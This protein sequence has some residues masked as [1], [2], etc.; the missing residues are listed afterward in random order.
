VVAVRVPQGSIE[1]GGERWGSDVLVKDDPNHEEGHPDMVSS[2]DGRFYVAVEYTDQPRID[3]LISDDGGRHWHSW[4]YVTATPGSVVK[5][6]ALAVPEVTRDWLYLTA[7]VNGWIH[8][9]ALSINTTDTRDSYVEPDPDS[10]GMPRITTDDLDYSNYYIYLMYNGAR[11][12]R[13]TDKGVNWT[14][15]GPLDPDTHDP[16]LPDIAYASDVLYATWT[17]SLGTYVTQLRRST[18]FG[19]SWDPV[20]GLI[21]EGINP[22]VGAI[23]DGSQAIVASTVL[24]GAQRDVR[25]AYTTDWG[26]TWTL[27]Q[28]LEC[29]PGV[30]EAF[31][32]LAV[33]PYLGEFRL[34]FYRNGDI[35]YRH[36]PYSNLTAWS[37]GKVVNES[38]YADI[39]GAPPGISMRFTTGAVGIA[40]NDSRPATHAIVFDSDANHAFYCGGPVEHPLSIG[41]A[42]A[43]ADS[44]DTLF[45]RDGTY[46]GINNRDIDLGGKDLVIRSEHGDPAACIVDCEGSPSAPHRGFRIHSGETSACRIEGITIRNGYTTSN[47][48]GI[49]IYSSS[50]VI[51]NCVF[52]GNQAYDGAGIC[53]Y[54]GQPRIDHCTFTGNSA[55]DAGGGLLIHSTT[56]QV[57]DC[58]FWNNFATWGGGAYYSLNDP[59]TLTNCTFTGNS[60]THWGG[61]VHNQFSGTQPY[62]AFCVFS[63][64]SA[65]EGGA[66]YNRSGASVQLSHC[67]LYGNAAAG[68]SGIRLEGSGAVILERTIVS[69]GTAGAAV[70]CTGS[71]SAAAV[72]SDVFGNAGG[73]YAGCLAGWEGVAGNF[74]SDPLFCDAAEGNLTLAA[75][76]PCLPPNNSCTETIGAFG[77]GCGAS[78]APEI[79][80]GADALQFSVT[81]N[82]FARRTEIVLVLGGEERIDL[83]VYDPAGRCVRHLASGA[84]FGA[85]SYRLAWRGEDDAGRPVPAG[86][87]VC[88]LGSGTGSWTR[89]VIA[90]R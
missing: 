27:N 54:L 88:R 15:V 74:A 63:Q 43:H 39:F 86:V 3:V 23:V 80:S 57:S 10:H 14:L 35:V 8:V 75:D 76:S 77:E 85:G 16:V 9:Y 55:G 87:Y 71:A 84:R 22:R 29:D 26:A 30:T 7:Y 37:T 53:A 70:V 2:G 89:R 28:C 6:P 13:S 62:F 79:P 66:I 47:G 41:E 17:H 60:S 48:G 64:N 34:A 4:A 18:D 20:V 1:S 12:A 58:V 5:D 82:P 90:I 65:A 69:F 46:T 50:P 49:D 81:P 44:G 59:C 36:A 73:D 52:S 78:A 42:V 25:Y 83:A 32:D 72:C 33:D 68:G 45:L 67:T 51:S 11:F 56:A 19:D 21:P 31:P 61:A 24:V 40:W 38:H